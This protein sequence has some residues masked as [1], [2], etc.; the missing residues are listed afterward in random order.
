MLVLLATWATGCAQANTRPNS[1]RPATLRPPASVPT[2]DRPGPTSSTEM[3][4]EKLLIAG[5]TPVVI[6]AAA[7]FLIIKYTGSRGIVLQ[8]SSGQTETI[9]SEEIQGA[10]HQPLDQVTSLRSAATACTQITE[11]ME[12]KADVKQPKAI[13]S[14][15]KGCSIVK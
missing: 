5:G 1:P 11:V 15:S 9:S 6:T 2:P 13:I 14:V 12:T 10:D 4:Q 3:D 8:S 7:D